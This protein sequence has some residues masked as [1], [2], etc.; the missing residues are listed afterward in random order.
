MEIAI[1]TNHLHNHENCP[2]FPKGESIRVGALRCLIIVAILV[3][4]CV[5]RPQETVLKS[6]KSSPDPGLRK[7]CTEENLMAA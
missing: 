7:Q 1:P 5:R 2:R 6:D 3:S 4:I